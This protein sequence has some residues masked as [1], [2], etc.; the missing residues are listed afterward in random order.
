MHQVHDVFKIQGQQVQ[1]VTD[2][3]SGQVRLEVRPFAVDDD[4]PTTATLDLPYSYAPYVLRDGD[5]L[6]LIGIEPTGQQ[7]IHNADFTTVTSPKLRGVFT[8]TNEFQTLYYYGWSFYNYY[9]NPYTGL[10]LRNQI[11]PATFRTVVEGKNGRRDWESKLRFLDLRDIDA[12]KMAAGEVPMNDYPF[13]NKITH[14][15]VLYSTHVEQTKSAAGTT[16]LYHVRS[17]V[18]RVDVTDPDHPKALPSVNVPGYLVDVSAD[19]GLWY[20][21][22]YQWDEFGRRRNSLNV[23]R[24]DGDK[25]VLMTVVPVADQI[26]RA[27]MRPGQ[28]SE[29]G[30]A[31]TGWSDRT[32][33]LTAHKY[34]W[35]GVHADTVASRQPYTVLERLDFSPEGLLA[36]DSKT[37]LAGYHF[38]LLDVEANRIYLAS[39]GP[40]GL[41]VLDGANLVS[42]TVLSTARTLSYI[43]RIV[44]DN[45]H[46][47]APLGWFGLQRY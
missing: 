18:D 23:L 45:Q 46:L 42:P 47:Y 39:N 10:P 37:S 6:H 35:W 36:A 43:S 15:N 33:W 13:I 7:V 30:G 4:G 24:P 38:D 3:Y 12:P 44:E 5:V 2:A 31:P 32:I 17:F 28:L 26:N 19:G 11:I 29:N 34:P 40:T 22:D 16:L 21:V 1:L 8:L 41:L 14:G 27:A 20:T 25:A 9:W